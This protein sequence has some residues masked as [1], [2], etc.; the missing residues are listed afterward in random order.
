[1]LSSFDKQIAESLR[2]TVA[3]VVSLASVVAL[4]V[5]YNGIRI[6]LS[7]RSRE[8]ASLRVL[9]FTRREVAMM[10]FG[11]QGA[12]DTVGTPLGLLL[13]LALAYWIAVGFESELYRFPVVV[14]PHTYLF[15]AAVVLVAGV[16]AA[17]LM[18]RRIYNLDLVSVLKTRE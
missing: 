4:G 7:E 1:M 5:I 6:A 13:G 14:Q 17:S 15:A 3:I 10:L 2:L 12:I 11:E 8:L 9:G 18:R 16:I